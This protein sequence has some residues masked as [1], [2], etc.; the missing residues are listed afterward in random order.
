VLRLQ[1]ALALV[2]P[3]LLKKSAPTEFL[4]Q[5]VLQ[6][7]AVAHRQVLHHVAQTEKAMR[8]IR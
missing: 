3:N 5:L 4:Q 2:T 6:P 1:N 7:E 8:Q